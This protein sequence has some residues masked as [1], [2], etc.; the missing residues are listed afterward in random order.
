[1]FMT[2]KFDQG[3]K[4]F[5]VVKFLYGQ[6]IICCQTY[7]AWCQMSTFGVRMSNIWLT[8]LELVV[9]HNLTANV[10]FWCYWCAHPLMSWLFKLHI[11][12]LIL[13]LGSRIEK[14]LSA[15][16]WKMSVRPAIVEGKPG[17]HKP[18]SK[19]KDNDDYQQQIIRHRMKQWQNVK[20]IKN[21]FLQHITIFYHNF[22]TS[23]HTTASIGQGK[24][25]KI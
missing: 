11:L 10:K 21:T 7:N 5:T 16:L 25:C 18:K 2:S 6:S 20:W 9:P 24:K 15:L 23:P 13:S 8:A 4:I 3:H 17:A 14:R 1:M 22:S 12:L 19:H